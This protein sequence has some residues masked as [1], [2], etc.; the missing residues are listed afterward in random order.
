MWLGQEIHLQLNHVR[1]GVLTIGAH[2]GVLYCGTLGAAGRTRTNLS[3]AVA[4]REAAAE[5]VEGPEAGHAHRI[6]HF[7]MGEWKPEE[8]VQLDGHTVY[9]WTVPAK[10]LDI[11]N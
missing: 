7:D 9:F 6:A 5:A 1:E 8:T 2:H 10:P 4:Q 11:Q 3:P